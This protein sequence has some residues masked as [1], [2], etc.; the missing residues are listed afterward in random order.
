[1]MNCGRCG[2]KIFATKEDYGS[3]VDLLKDLDD[4]FKVKIDVQ[5]LSPPG[6]DP[7]CK[8]FQIHEPPS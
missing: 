6:P 8:S 4:F 1:M 3:F 5:S 7:G 2:E